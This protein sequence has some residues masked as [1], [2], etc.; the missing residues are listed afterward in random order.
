MYRERERCYLIGRR[1]NSQLRTGADK[2]CAAAAPVGARASQES[3]I[4]R[5]PSLGVWVSYWGWRPS[6][7]CSRF[8]AGA[9]PPKKRPPCLIR[10]PPFCKSPKEVAVKL[11]RLLAAHG[12][13]VPADLKHVLVQ[14]RQ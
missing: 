10:N 6:F 9:P 12:H 5:T 3:A 7:V 14:P 13:K 8:C 2:F 1:L 11:E 4:Q